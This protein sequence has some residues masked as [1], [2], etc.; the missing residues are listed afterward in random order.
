M[1]AK[2]CIKC[3]QWKARC[4]VPDSGSGPCSRCR[5]HNL[6]CVFDA[7]YKR[8]SK[9][10]RM[11]QMVSE[12]RQLRASLREPAAAACGDDNASSATGPGWSA[13]AEPISVLPL[14]L[15][16]P[17]G[18]IVVATSDADTTPMH[19]VPG[20]NSTI[21]A[22][23]TRILSSVSV[24]NS[25]QTSAS[26]PTTA[27]PVP[28][29]AA[30]AAYRSL[31][32][33]HFTRSQIERYFRVYFGHYHPHLPFKMTTESPD[34]T[35]ARSP[36]LFWIICAVTSNWK[37]QSVMAPLVKT[38]ISDAMHDRP[39]TVETVQALLIMCLWPFR[40]VHI[41]DDPSQFYSSIAA[42]MALQLN[43][44]RPDQPYWPLRHG[45][46]HGPHMA[47]SDHDV[48][49]TT[50]LA[51]Y[52]VDQIQAAQMGLPP[53]IRADANLLAAVEHPAVPAVL[54]RLCRL[55]HL[56]A[57]IAWTIGTNASTPTGL[58]PP[59]ER[60]TLIRQYLEKLARLQA[61]DRQQ[62]QQN[63]VSGG[64]S[65]GGH[66]G[67]RL[68]ALY[69][70]SQLGSY[71]LLTDMPYSDGL[72]DLVADAEAAAC[73]LIDVAHG[74]N[75]ITAP[76]YFHWAMIHA[77]FVLVRLLQM[78]YDTQSEVL[79]DSIERVCQSLRT[80]VTSPDDLSAKAWPLLQGLQ[81]LQDKQKT[82][83]LLSRMGVSLF[84]DLLRVSWEQ[85][86]EEVIDDSFD[87]A[88]FDWNTLGM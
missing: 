21:S 42:R 6:T 19:S 62:Q 65:G 27:P 73:E 58:V 88:Q 55:Y 60:P 87:M 56:Q 16:P 85:N 47:S 40:T 77:G 33:I 29:S 12:L 14:P 53:A 2:A 7:S 52:V 51:C 74:I 70:R 13:A 66:E 67:V 68:S 50:W 25:L 81:Y 80:I 32:D 59:A 38:I 84:Y 75:M 54:A 63:A 49:R 28:A 82:P 71:A 57:E 1:K 41:S 9:D 72:R 10:K 15:P 11:Q 35:H 69:A 64:G 3:R 31:G 61:A 26:I 37:Q 45:S 23:S 36:L 34:E 76:V 48:R 39:Y 20:S 4:D 83:A 5:S 18:Q 22:A 43:L 78:P 86:L 46:F 24:A 8:L 79:Y 30:V 44:H 17:A